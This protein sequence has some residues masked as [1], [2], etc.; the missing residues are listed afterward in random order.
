LPILGIAMVV[1]ETVG[2]V[3]TNPRLRARHRHAKALRERQVS[4]DF[5][6]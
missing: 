5:K 2:S 3:V 4:F 1:G 6:D